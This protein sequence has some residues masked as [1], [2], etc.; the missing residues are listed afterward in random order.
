VDY[1]IDI[2]IASPLTLA[3]VR[4]TVPASG[5]ATAWKPALDRVWVFLRTNSVSNSGLNVFVYHHPER[6][7]EA[8]NI[9][10]GVQ[11]SSR[12]DDGAGDVKCV[13]TPA[14][15]VAKTV[16][17]GPYNRL[18]DAHAAIHQW[19]KTNQRSIAAASWEVYGHWNNDPQKLETTIRYLLA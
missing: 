12:F 15:E 14:G 3:A 4:A 18:G 5:I 7:G 1:K 8:M 9:D 17:I 6:S 19:C 2:E 16:H 11:V 10:F 13:E